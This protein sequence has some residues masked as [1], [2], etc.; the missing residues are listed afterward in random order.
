MIITTQCID[1][2][3]LNLMMKKVSTNC[4]LKENAKTLKYKFKD[5]K[6][7]NALTETYLPGPNLFAYL[8]GPLVEKIPP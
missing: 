8:P 2:L 5:A 7:L 1:I 6:R 3:G 4:C